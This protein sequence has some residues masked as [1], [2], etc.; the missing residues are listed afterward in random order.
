MSE[1]CVFACYSL[2]EEC[3]ARLAVE[4]GGSFGWERFVGSRDA[5]VGM[6][7]F[8]ASGPALAERFGF[9]KQN[10]LKGARARLG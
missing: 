3:K 2:P 8:G 4:A 6:S 7:Q 9:T 1:N 10:V 5:V